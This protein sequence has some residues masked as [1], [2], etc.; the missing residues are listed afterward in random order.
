VSADPFV[1]KTGVFRH[2]FFD[3]KYGFTQSPTRLY[4]HFLTEPL[5]KLLF[6]FD[7]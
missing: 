6:I 5:S 3:R 1:K 2:L 7:R 4:G